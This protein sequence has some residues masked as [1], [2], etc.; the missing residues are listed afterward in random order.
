MQRKPDFL[1][2]GAAKSGTTSLCRYLSEY[3]SIKI[4]S[5]RLEFFGEYLNPAFGNLS[6]KEYLKYFENVADNQ[7]AGEKSVSYLYSYQAIDEIYE[8]NPLMKIVMVLRNPVERAYSDYWHRK[9]TGVEPLSFEDALKEENNRIANGSRIEL[10]YANYGLYFAHVSAYIEKFGR[11]NVFVIRFEDLKSDP[12][13]V[14]L[15]CTKFLGMATANALESYP[16][17]NKGSRGRKNIILRT[18]QLM[19]RQRLLVLA[20]RTFVPNFLRTKITGWMV[21]SNQTD[22]YPPINKEIEKKLKNFFHEDIK[23]LE[24]LL[25]WDLSSW[26]T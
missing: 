17:Y 6:L 22:E 14:C 8:I 2:V 12:M 4:V 7:I 1:I 25:N 13:K 16:V 23:K 15:A 18:L 10:H 26:R 19:A 24:N 3:S 9:R 11:D 5:E 20:A 21:A